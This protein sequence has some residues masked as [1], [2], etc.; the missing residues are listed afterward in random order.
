MSISPYSVFLPPNPKE[1][2]LQIKRYVQIDRNI[3]LAERVFNLASKEG[4]WKLVE[5][6]CS[7]DT[8]YRY[9]QKGD[10]WREQAKELINNNG[11][12]VR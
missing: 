9:L 12:S 1:C 2:F 11:G 6:S 10:D 3:S 4:T 7:V 8:F 5:L